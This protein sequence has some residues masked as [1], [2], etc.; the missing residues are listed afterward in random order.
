VNPGRGN[1]GKHEDLFQRR[2]TGIYVNSLLNLWL[3]DCPSNTMHSVRRR[4]WWLNFTELTLW[5][6]LL[7]KQRERERRTERELRRSG[8]RELF[9]D[10][11][12]TTMSLAGRSS[13]FSL[14][15]PALKSGEELFL[16]S[17]TR[18]WRNFTRH[19]ECVHQ[20]HWLME[21]GE[22]L[23]LAVVSR[24]ASAA[25]RRSTCETPP[26]EQAEL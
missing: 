15:L 10:D 12:L 11:C 14:T 6:F 25:E 20:R 5:R 16:R 21:S 4:S 8:R 9:F 22:L 2:R 18:E 24:S 26:C 13:W 7:C 19:A 17:T 23:A 1:V 3:F